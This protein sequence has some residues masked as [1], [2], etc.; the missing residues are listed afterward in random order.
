[1]NH[2]ESWQALLYVLNRQI[3]GWW[4]WVYLRNNLYYNFVI[5]GINQY[6]FVTKIPR[7]QSDCLVILRRTCFLV[8][9]NVCFEQHHN[10]SI[11]NKTEIN[12]TPIHN[13]IMS[14]LLIGQQNTS[15]IVIF[16]HK[17]YNNDNV[18]NRITSRIHSGAFLS[19]KWNFYPFIHLYLCIM[20]SCLFP[21]MN[22]MMLLM[23]IINK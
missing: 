18:R 6:L 1:M 9:I 22:A 7:V 19:I 16:V 3:S 11:S 17:S 21:K 20:G 5:L 15:K 8:I 14:I 23:T 13:V 10:K 4:H 12:I 2:I